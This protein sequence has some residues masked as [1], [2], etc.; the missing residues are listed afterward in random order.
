MEESSWYLYFTEVRHYRRGGPVQRGKEGP[1]LQRGMERYKGWL[2][3]PSTPLWLK[4]EGRHLLADSHLDILLD[5]VQFKPMIQVKGIT[6]GY[7]GLMEALEAVIQIVDWVYQ[8]RREDTDIECE[9]PEL[10]ASCAQVGGAR[11]PCTQ[12]GGTRVSSAQEGGARASSCQ[13]PGGGSVQRPGGGSPSVLRPGRGSRCVLRS[14]GG[15]RCVL[16]PRRGSRCVHSPRRGR[17]KVHSPASVSGLGTSSPLGYPG[18][19]GVLW[20]TVPPGPRPEEPMIQVKG[21]TRGY[22]G[23]MEALEAVIQI[24]DWVYQERREDT[25]IECEEPERPAS[26]AQV[27]GARAPCAQEGGTRVSSAQEG[28]A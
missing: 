11:A 26:C 12:E 23:L 20:I 10:P 13:R 21:I 4:T 17:L 27:G 5:F 16:R 7:P 22:P 8:E 28:G 3:D 9:E 18:T 6:R 2:R 15:S 14:R 1:P 25:D 19:R 24:V